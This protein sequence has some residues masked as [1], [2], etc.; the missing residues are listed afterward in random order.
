MG[1][2]VSEVVVEDVEE[3]CASRGGWESTG[4]DHEENALEGLRGVHQLQRI[5]GGVHG[6]WNGDVGRG[7]VWKA[8]ERETVT[9]GGYDDS[10][11]VEKP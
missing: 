5:E 1:D 2:A 11:H 6:F 4:D 8:E 3:A 9:T 10:H 7:N